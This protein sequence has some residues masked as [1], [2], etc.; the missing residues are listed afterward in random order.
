MHWQTHAAIV[1]VGIEHR[2]ATKKFDAFSLEIRCIG[3]ALAFLA[4]LG[5]LR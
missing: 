1:V 3:K 5:R 2:L 4:F